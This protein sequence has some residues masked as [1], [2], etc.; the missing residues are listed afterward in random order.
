MDHSVNCI[1]LSEVFSD[2]FF[3]FF[4]CL[5]QE[6]SCLLFFLCFTQL[7]KPVL[8]FP[9]FNASFCFSLFYFQ[10]REK[11]KQ[12]FMLCHLSALK[13]C[14]TSTSKLFQSFIFVTKPS[15]AKLLP[16]HTTVLFLKCIFI[17]KER[18]T[19]VIP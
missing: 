14:Q 10:C 4:V 12:C 6:N 17:T 19:L 5:N 11:W 7:A 15:C 8:I 2:V 3:F 13:H 18:L 9:P 16:T 1:L